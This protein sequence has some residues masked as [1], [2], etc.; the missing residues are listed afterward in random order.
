MK[1]R[2]SV[3]LTTLSNG[4]EAARTILYIMT[5]YGIDRRVV[6]EDAIVASI[7]LMR[8]NIAKNILPAINDCGHI[9]TGMSKSQLQFS[10]VPTKKRRRRSS[11]GDGS[12]DSDTTLRDMKKCYKSVFKLIGYTV[13]LMERI[14]TLIQR[15]PL[16]DQHIMTCSAGALV[17]LE[18]DPSTDAA[19]Q[20]SHQLHVATIS[21]VTSI[22]RMYS[23]LRTLIVEDL[24]ALMLKMPSGK[25]GMRTFPIQSSNVMNPQKACEFSKSL[26]MG[27]TG[28]SS[29]PSS[30]IQPISIIVMNL[31]QSSVIRP[32]FESM[33]HDNSEDAN[34]QVNTQP[35]LI[36]GLRACQAVSD[37]FVN[38][39]L[40]RCSRKGEDGGASEFR[41]ILN[42]LIEDLLL[43]LLVPEFPAAEMIV[44]SIANCMYHDIIQMTTSKRGKE[45]ITTTYFNTIFDALGKISAAVAR[46]NK[47]NEE[48]CA[49]LD[50]PI[51]R[52]NKNTKNSIQHLNC[53]CN[54]TEF[55][56][57]F[58]LKCDRCKA[59][60]HGECIGVSQ[61]DVPEKWLCDGCQ[62]NTIVEFEVDRNTNLGELSCSSNLIDRPYCLRRLVID[63]L[64]VMSLNSEVMGIRDAYGFQLA[65]WLNQLDSAIASNKCNV[66]SRGNMSLIPGLIG[67]WDPQA[68]LDLN[69]DYISSHRSLSGMFN[70]LSDEGRSRMIVDFTCKL[71]TLLI[72]FRSQVGRIVKLLESPSKSVRKLSLKAIEKIADADPKLMTIPFVRNAVTRRFSDESISVRDAVVSLVG[73]YVVNTPDVA[74]AFHPALIHSLSDFGVSVRKRTVLVLLDILLTNS[75]YEGR[76]EAC[77]MMLRLAAD[78][79]EDDTVR[80]L[81]YDLFS[82][83]WLDTADKTADGNR[84]ILHSSRNLDDTSPLSKVSNLD[85][86][87]LTDTPLG[88]NTPMTDSDLIS[89]LPNTPHTNTLTLPTKTTRSTTKKVTTRYLQIRCETAVHQMVEVVKTANT[90]HDLTILFRELLSDTPDSDK[91]KKS[92]ARKKRNGLAKNQIAMLVDCLFEKLL[93]VEEDNEKSTTEKGGDLISIFR[94][95]KVFTDVSP[96]DVLRHLDTL[97]PYLKI[98]NGLRPIDEGTFL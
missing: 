86:V 82:K 85:I 35:R 33:E 4:L 93:A 91:T 30:N 13:L 80:D 9:T 46:I 45:S 77:S 10:P 60:F 54:E 98:D 63:Y 18:L 7:V 81:I 3:L 52:K 66:E 25:R 16:D 36:S 79:K 43:V 92:S 48:N 57:K 84:R 70:C 55:G 44:L 88:S 71:S 69:D 75:K 1:G 47:W 34:N 28:S 58:M 32:S 21:L 90:E 59:W 89:H 2:G 11:V 14:D 95:L 96:L 24:F 42:N 87:G 40:R 29:P 83:I 53:Y 39:L 41:P 61:D 38:H 72:S 50:L 65:R 94:T 20:L 12:S 73:S 62:F 26:W 5:S 6:K 23:K 67:L 51:I 22:F 49:R 37:F 64:S 27:A 74:N 76:A 56:D 17:S 68:S 15:T 78:P 8:H 31:V 19:V 97:L